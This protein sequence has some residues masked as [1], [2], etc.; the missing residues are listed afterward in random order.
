MRSDLDVIDFI[1]RQFC[2]MQVLE[3]VE[4]LALPDCWV[5]A[6][7]VRDAVWD[8][9]HARPALG[10]SSRD[11]D[12]VYFD[13]HHG[14]ETDLRAAN[15]LRRAYPDLAW[16]IKNQARM[17]IRNGDPGYTC[18]FDALRYWPETATAVAV[19]SIE[20]QVEIVAPYGIDDL[21][22]MVVRPTPPFAHKLEQ[23]DRRLREK[24]WTMRW[25]MVRVERTKVG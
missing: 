18:T 7:F 1:Q 14:A 19:R 9:L 21:V 2:M 15:L 4:G 3:A 22:H 8:R 6:G 13:P 12:V 16:D 10:V 23:F 24:N 11:V 17:H 20:G 25:P 5:G